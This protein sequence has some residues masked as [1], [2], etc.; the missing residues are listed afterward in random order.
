MNEKYKV[1][2]ME[3]IK[4]KNKKRMEKYRK[5]IESQKNVSSNN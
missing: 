2:R 3:K 4:Q 1:K 5:Y